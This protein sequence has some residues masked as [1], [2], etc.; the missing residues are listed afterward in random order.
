M[1][2][3]SCFAPVA[4]RRAK[5][6][7]LGSMPG[8]ASLAAGR[9]YA[10]P[11]NSFWPIM[12]AVFAGG[13]E[14][15]YPARLRLLKSRGVALW[16]VLGSCVRPGSSDSAIERASVVVNDFQAFLRSHPGIVK[17][18]FNGSKAEECYR[19]YVLPA[20]L[21]GHGLRYRRL[22]STSP[23]R[24]TLTASQKLS[25]WRQALISR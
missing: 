23:A 4:D 15:S 1:A 9:Y 18:L 7:V 16:D 12:E 22:P 8:A 25:A 19:R 6:L 11:R 13:E 2:R 24:A 21:P 20:L 5:I 3:V 17:V 10:H 14:L